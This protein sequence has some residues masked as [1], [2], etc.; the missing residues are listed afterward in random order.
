MFVSSYFPVIELFLCSFV[1]GWIHNVN[2]LNDE[3]QNNQYSK[4]NNHVDDTNRKWAWSFHVIIHLSIDGCV[5]HPMCGT[6]HA[7][8]EKGTLPAKAGSSFL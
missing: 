3:S 7:V 8:K 2:Q 4:Y 6:A 1:L 5:L